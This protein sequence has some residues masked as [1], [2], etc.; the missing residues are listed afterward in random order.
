MCV[1]ACVCVYVCV[2][3][4]YLFVPVCLSVRVF[5]SLRLCVPVFAPVLH[6]KGGAGGEN[7]NFYCEDS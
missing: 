2:L 7:T 1:D 5:I 6:E 3:C 4:R